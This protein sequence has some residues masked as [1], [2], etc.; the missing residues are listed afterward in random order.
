[1][2]IGRHVKAGLGW[3]QC[4]PLHV[5]VLVPDVC[6]HS[7][8]PLLCHGQQVIFTYFLAPEKYI[9]NGRRERKRRK[10]EAKKIE[11]D[12]KKVI[13]AGINVIQEQ[14]EEN[15]NSDSPQTTFEKPTAEDIKQLQE[16]PKKLSEK[17][18]D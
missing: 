16:E 12:E 5:W 14:L 2:K 17:K 1:M 7:G 3:V 6:N 15:E 18:S 8:S 10:E 4:D 11:A 13:D 9:F